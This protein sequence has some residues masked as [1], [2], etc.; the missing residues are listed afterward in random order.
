MEIKELATAKHVEKKSKFLAYLYA[1]E[2]E[3]ELTEI[4]SRIKKE[5]QKAAHVCYG[6]VC[7]K[8]EVFK[9]DGEVGHP[10]R[11]LLELLK[12]HNKESHILLVARYYGGVKLGPGGVSRA[13]RA[14]GKLC[15]ESEEEN[16]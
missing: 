13:F 1:V 2:T 5:H 12:Q 9:N 4:I 14:A 10:G 11:G 7:N 15:F 6:S 8:E 3:E 16:K